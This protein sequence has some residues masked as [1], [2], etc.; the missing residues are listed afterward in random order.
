MKQFNL[1]GIRFCNRLPFYTRGLL[2]VEKHCAPAIYLKVEVSVRNF[3]RGCE[4]ELYAAVLEYAV[5]IMAGNRTYVPILHAE[6]DV[7]ESVIV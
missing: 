6:N 3:W 1:P 7:Y 2:K 5:L 4:E